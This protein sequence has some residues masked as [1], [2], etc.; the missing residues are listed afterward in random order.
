MG[1]PPSCTLIIAYTSQKIDIGAADSACVYCVPAAL[2]LHSNALYVAGKG[3][4]TDFWE[5]YTIFRQ[6]I[7]Q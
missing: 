1:K 7:L 2:R 3:A 5:I 6:A 4:G